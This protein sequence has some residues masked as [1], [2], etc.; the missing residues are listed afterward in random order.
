MRAMVYTQYGNPDVLHSIELEIP[1]PGDNE[2][3]IDVHAAS[4]N[5]FD[6]RHLTADPFLVRLAG[7]GYRDPPQS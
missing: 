7:G 4:V 1:V 6:W 2:V 3:L 5:A